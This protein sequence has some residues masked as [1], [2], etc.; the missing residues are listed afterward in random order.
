MN[1]DIEARL[2]RILKTWSTLIDTLAKESMAKKVKRV[3]GRKD[4]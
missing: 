4:E 1:N 2:S 3:K